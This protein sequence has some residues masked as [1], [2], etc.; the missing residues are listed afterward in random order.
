[1]VSRDYTS[2]E[3]A[4]YAVS[5]LSLCLVVGNHH[6]CNAV[7]AVKVVEQCHHFGAHSRVKVTRRFVGEDY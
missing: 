6:D 4:H 7:F 1:M 2:V 3:E 5:L